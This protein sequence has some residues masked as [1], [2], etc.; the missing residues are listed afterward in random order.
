MEEHRLATVSAQLKLTGNK[1]KGTIACGDQGG[2]AASIGHE[3][4]DP[5]LGSKARMGI[6]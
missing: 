1:T 3:A 4:R 2:A 5:A 6:G